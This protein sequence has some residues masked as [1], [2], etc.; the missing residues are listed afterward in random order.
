MR[1]L[2]LGGTAFMGPHVVRRLV[3]QGHDV[4]VYHRGQHDVGL[5]DRVTHIHE[6]ASVIGNRRLT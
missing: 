1:V 5:P 3:D 4:A 2:I 6:P